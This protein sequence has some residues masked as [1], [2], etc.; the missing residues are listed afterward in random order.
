MAGRFQNG[1]LQGDHVRFVVHTEDLCHR[2][3]LARRRVRA[4]SWGGPVSAEVLAR[5]GEDPGPALPQLSMTGEAEVNGRR[6]EALRSAATKSLLRPPPH[7]L[8][9]RSSLLEERS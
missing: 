5:G 3:V 7:I 2:Q 9:R 4:K 6:M 8:K 1:A